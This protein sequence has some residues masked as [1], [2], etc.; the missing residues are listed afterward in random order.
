MPELD[1]FASNSGCN[2]LL[3]EGGGALAAAL[4]ASGRVDRLVIL[5]API[6]IGH[7][8]GLEQLPLPT[9]ADAHGRW[10]PQYNRQLGTDRLEVYRPSR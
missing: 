4:I 3:C 1:H 10:Q 7:G 2:R 8:I 9:L 6:L 5:R